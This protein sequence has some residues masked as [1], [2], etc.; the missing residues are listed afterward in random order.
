DLNPLGDGIRHVS[1]KYSKVSY[2]ASKSKGNGVKEMESILISDDNNNI[3]KYA[4]RYIGHQF[5]SNDIG[6][7][8]QNSIEIN[9][10][11]LLSKLKQLGNRCASMQ[12]R[13]L[14][15]NLYLYNIIKM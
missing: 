4:R 11:V 12:Y 8:R 7:N 1:Q 9:K 14:S 6:G 5:F 10:L 3:N 13:G 15:E 2:T